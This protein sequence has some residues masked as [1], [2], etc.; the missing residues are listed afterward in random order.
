MF[1]GI[2]ARRT[3]FPGGPGLGSGTAAGPGARP[4]P[5]AGAGSG[6]ELYSLGVFILGK[7]EL[8]FE[9]FRHLS[10]RSDW[11]MYNGGVERRAPEARARGVEIALC[12]FKVQ[13]KPLEPQTG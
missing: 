13:L 5:G 9:R 11:G 12:S 10:R 3:L 8:Y 4:W 1:A 2:F 6:G 7:R